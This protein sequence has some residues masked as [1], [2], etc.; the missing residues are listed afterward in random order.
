MPRCLRFGRD[1]GE[2]GHDSDI[3]KP[4]RTTPERTFQLLIA[5]I[6]D[7]RRGNL[8]EIF[9]NQAK[10]LFRIATLPRRKRHYVRERL[11]EEELVMLRKMMIALLAQPPL[12]YLHLMS[13]RRAAG[14][15]VAEVVCTAAA[16]VAAVVASAV[17]AALVAAVASVAPRSVVVA[18]AF[19]RPRWVGDFVQPQ[20]AEVVSVQP[21][22][23][24]VVSVQP[25]L[26]QALASALQPLAGQA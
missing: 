20:L 3:A 10:I 13:S 8:I 25:P 14:L 26:V 16:A 18:A 17:A 9:G 7:R 19:V 11:D 21:Q 2:S 12:Q 6:V 23:A 5:S 15:V 1:P 4:T 24:A 22:L